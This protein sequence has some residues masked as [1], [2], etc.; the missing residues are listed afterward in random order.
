VRLPLPRLAAIA[1][2]I[3]GA[4]LAALVAA[5]WVHLAGN[6]SS[7]MAGMHG[8]HGTVEALTRAGGDPLGP[9]LSTRLLTSWQLD[10][11]AVAV[12]VLV[13]A[14]YLT[15][16]ALVPI[17][18]GHRWPLRRT[19]CFLL[20]LAVC[21]FATCGSIAVY[22]QVL[23]TAHM[24]GH[25]A[26]VMVAPALLVAGHPLTLLLAASD[27]PRRSRIAR[28]LTGRVM[29]VLTA[30]PVAL[31]A[32]TVVIVGSHLT[33]LMD[34]IMRN[35]WA[36]QVE[37][38]VY[39]LVGCQFF[40]LVV[41]NEPIRWRLA[42]PARWLLLAVAM[43]VDTFTGIVLLQGTHAVSMLSDPDLHVDPLQ[44]TR[45]GGAIMWFAGDGIMIVIMIALVIGWLRRADT[46][47]ADRKG[48][49][50]QARVATFTERTTQTG[51]VDTFDE[52]EVARASYNEW[53]AGLNNGMDEQRR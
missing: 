21:G 36:G 23:F 50:E 48:W 14:A 26:L 25:L 20:G 53:L 30:P 52:D 24:A 2:A 40:V 38:L 17:R 13:A 9:L 32:Y 46:D 43:A 41:G 45:T 44:D 19:V 47:R 8:M 34:E 15:G 49:L 3:A 18:T 16:V 4:A 6:T 11:V 37:H 1:W 5:V 51:D 28:I 27:A 7:G 42:T 29:S 12:L 35:T 10:A 33:G 39:V 31:A 22:D